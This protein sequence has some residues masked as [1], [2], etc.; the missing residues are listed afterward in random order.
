MQNH[1]QTST[2][3]RQEIVYISDESQQLKEQTE[4][5]NEEVVQEK[6][7]E[8]RVYQP[9]IPFPQRLKQT[10]LDDQFFKF[11]NVFRKLEINIPFV[12]ALNQMPHYAKFMKD[13]ISKKSNL[14]QKGV[15]S[16]FANYGAIIQ[17]K[18]P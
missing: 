9:L 11:L 12:E 17:K 15:V 13:I 2:K 3:K 14:D 8:V 5:K 4:Q 18:L 1:N 10:K 7:E 6:K 16:L